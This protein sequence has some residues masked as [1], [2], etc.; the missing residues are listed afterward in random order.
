M[1]AVFSGSW[2]QICCVHVIVW[3]FLLMTLVETSTLWVELTGHSLY[4]S[5]CEMFNPV[6]NTWATIAPM[7]YPVHGH[8]LVGLNLYMYAVGGTN[9]VSILSRA[10]KY[11]INTNTWSNLPSLPAPRVGAVAA[12]ANGEITIVGGGPQDIVWLDRSLNTWVVVSPNI[13]TNPFPAGYSFPKAGLANYL[14]VFVNSGLGSDTMTPSVYVVDTDTCR[15]GV[16][17]PDLP[18]IYDGG[19]MSVFT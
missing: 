15:E 8:A 18:Q 12:V 3:T 7:P 14:A 2:D 13:N 5:N 1:T 10:S 9:G 16:Y 17:Y 11:N 19:A 6:T 4:L